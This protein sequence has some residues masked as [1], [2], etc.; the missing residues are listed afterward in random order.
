MGEGMMEKWN[1]SKA[2]DLYRIDSWGSGYFDINE[3]GNVTVFPDGNSKD[4]GQ[5]VDLYDLVN[6]LVKRKIEAPI[7]FRFDGI[8]QH[9]VKYLQ[10]AF[11]EAISKMQYEGVYR[12]AYPIKVNQQRHVV[13]AVRQAGSSQ[14][15]GLEVGSKP[16]LLAALAIH[17]S[18]D[19][20]LL[21]NGY[22]DREYLELAL[23][24]RKIGRRSIVIIEQLYE[25]EELLKIADE[26]GVE[27][28][29]GIRMKPSTRGSGR[30]E[31]SSGEKA[32]F[33]LN[34][35]EIVWAAQKLR[36][37]GKQ[38]CLKLLHFHI[39]SQ[40]TSIMSLKKALREGARVYVELSRLCPSLSFFD[41]G[42]GL[43]VDYDG[44]RTNFESSVNYTVEEYAH[45]VVSII[46]E[47]CRDA[48]I[49]QPDLISESGR[50]IVAHHALLVT[51]VLDVAPALGI[52]NDLGPAPSDHELIEK[53]TSL[54]YNLSVKNCLETLHSALEI[55]EEILNRFLQG[56]ISLLER[57]YADRTYR[58]LVAKLRGVSQS[59]KYVPEDLE[60][61]E[62]VL[63]DLYFCNFS[64]FQS[65]PDSWAIDQLF[66]LMPIHR[67]NEEP[68]RRAAIAD[69]TCDSDGKIDRFIDLK[70]VKDYVLFHSPNEKESYYVGIFLVGAYQEILGDLHNLFGDTNAVHV[71][72]D[73]DGEVDL[74]HV[75]EGDTIEEVLSYVEYA[76]SGLFENL[77][78]S[79]ER[80]VRTGKLSPEDAARIQKRYKEAMDG[81]TY[82]VK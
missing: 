18:S 80:S 45:D 23:L 63:R 12:V 22:K 43:G 47:S 72:I 6:S 30:W 40:I 65:L 4:N 36:E 64:L 51:E 74:T 61:L 54:Y 48:E 3:H 14:N 24:G 26:L 55:K 35:D 58:H 8:I 60:K 32:K 10:K 33:G 28:E 66:P 73:Q 25:L 17:D 34:S 19:A 69:L 67:L 75:I 68:T 71:N 46:G 82:L 81:Y 41:V 11:N 38:D 7:L 62:G 9:R 59:L 56:D 27:P 57:A 20:L 16:E 49:R 42:G 13:E 37:K 2:R 31:A 70:D 39:G 1:I 77:R 76:P 29:I 5:G 53:I 52:V 44:S 78:K 21:C 79:M 50:A 15:L